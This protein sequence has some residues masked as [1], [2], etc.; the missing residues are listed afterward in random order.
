M[1]TKTNAQARGDS[2]SPLAISLQN[3]SKN[4]GAVRANKDVSLSVR[5]GTIHGIV[6]ENGAGKSTFVKMVYGLLEPS[7]GTFYWNGKKI[8]IGRPQE[9]RNFGIGM[10]FQ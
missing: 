3:I 5:L 1:S 8:V 4:F 6:G 7:K 9:A 10:V 2:R